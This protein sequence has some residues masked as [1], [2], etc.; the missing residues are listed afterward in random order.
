MEMAHIPVA[1]G[2]S[3]HSASNRYVEE[4]AEHVAFGLADNSASNGVDQVW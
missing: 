3:D 1:F 4:S 2:L